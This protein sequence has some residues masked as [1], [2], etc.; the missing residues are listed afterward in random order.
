MFV[1]I[2]FLHLDKHDWGLRNLQYLNALLLASLKT[3]HAVAQAAILPL[4][5]F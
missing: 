4:G 1:T 2:D 3:Y 5:P